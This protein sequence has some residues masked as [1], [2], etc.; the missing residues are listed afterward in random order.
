MRMETIIRRDHGMKAHRVV[1]VR[2]ACRAAAQAGRFP[3]G[4]RLRFSGTESVALPA[5]GAV[6]PP[7][8]FTIG[9]ECGDGAAPV[10]WGVRCGS[11]I[12]PGAWC[13][14]GAAFGWKR[15]LG[16]HAFSA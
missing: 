2:P 12:A 3:G 6:G 15:C 10:Y 16:P 9:G 5:A 7:E 13:A 14:W 1:L 8:T 11:C 4:W